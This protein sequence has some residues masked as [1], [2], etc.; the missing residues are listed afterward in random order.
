MIA[1]PRLRRLSPAALGMTKAVVTAWLAVVVGC[2]GATRGDPKPPP[3]AATTRI[4][5]GDGQTVALPTAAEAVAARTTI[6]AP[7]DDVWGALPAAYEA[8]GMRV[9]TIDSKTRRIGNESMRARRRIGDIP[10]VRLLSCGGAIGA[11][12]AETFDI[13][14]YVISQ[15]SPASAGSTTLATV[16]QATGKSPN[17][18][19]NEVSCTSTGSLERRIE[20]LV[21]A[22]VAK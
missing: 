11:P 17:F 2:S 8:L 22:K 1:I 5:T 7:A 4:S 13:T 14:L 6:A 16:V 20:E 21:R 3:P 10:M 12:N 9:A 15:L 18:G 19:G